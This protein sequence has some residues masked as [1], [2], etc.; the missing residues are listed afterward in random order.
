MRLFRFS[1]WPRGSKAAVCLTYDDALPCHYDTVGPTLEEHNFRGTFYVPIRESLWT[2]GPAWRDLAHRGHELGNHTVFHPC[3]RDN[4]VVRDRIEPWNDLVDF[5]TNRLRR[6]LVTANGVL[7]LIDGREQRTYGN[8]CHDVAIGPS[9]R[10]TSIEP[11][12]EELFL[13]GRGPL[14]DCP[15]NPRTAPMSALG[16][17]MA[18]HRTFDEWR[19]RIEEAERAEALLILT[20]H[21]VGTGYGRLQVDVAQHRMLLDYLRDAQDRIWT[22]P[23][24]AVAEWL[25]KTRITEQ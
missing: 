20:F 13:A 16:T 3:R 21:G 25:I 11:L 2:A 19:R 10:Q 22:A 8:T 4:P 14:I 9:N 1:G 15:T 12:V 24:V 5:D 7:R 18:D 23:V 6:E 17:T